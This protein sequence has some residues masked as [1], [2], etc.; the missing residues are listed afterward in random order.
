MPVLPGAEPYRHEGGEVGVLL[1]HG[2]TGSPQ[3]LRPWAEFLAKRGLTVSLPLLPGHGTRWQDM[4][5]TGWQ[6]WYAEVDR[7]FRALSEQCGQVFVFGLSMGGAL[8]LRLAARHGDAISGIVVVNPANKVHGPAAHALP[9][10]RHLVRTTKG[11]ANDIAKEGM[12]EV[13]YDRVPLHAAHSLRNFLRLV[14]GE[15][16]QV[17]QPMLLLHSPQDH[18]VPPADSARIL[19]RV[20]S[21]DVREVLLEQSYHVAT[22][23]HD[24]ERIFE[25]SH[26]FLG[27]LAPSVGE[28][29][30]TTGG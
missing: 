25:E 26:A 11:L 18:V 12:D 13:A 2:F 29:G 19:S 3:S 4:A 24:A 27:R 30:S 8:T 15:L 21:T 5:V 23:D 20:S 16:P 7:E 6:D 28:K 10:A 1:C 22:L 17:T 14:D 9:V